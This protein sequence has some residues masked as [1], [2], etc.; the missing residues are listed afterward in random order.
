MLG[1]RQGATE[2]A[3]VVTALLEDLRE[4]GVKADVPTLFVLDGAKALQPAVKR[5]WG[6]FAHTAMPGSQASQCRS[7]SPGEAS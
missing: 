2:N 5:L 1:L 3:P 7:S 6:K 4:R